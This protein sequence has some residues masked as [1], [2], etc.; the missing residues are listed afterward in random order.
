MPDGIDVSRWQGSID[1][2]TVAADRAFAYIKAGG[3][4]GGYYADPLWSQNRN[5]S[6]GLLPR[7][8]YY[9][10]APGD[11][12]AQAKHFAGIVGDFSTL[13]L[14]PALDVEMVGIS[15]DQV[16]AFMATLES[17]TPCRW[18][19]P[20]GTPQVAIIYSGLALAGIF[21]K[22]WT[23]WDLWLAGYYGGPDK[24]PRIPGPWSAWSIWQWIGEG[25]RCLGVNGDC[26]QNIATDEWWNRVRKTPDSGDWLDMA[27]IDDVR[28]VVREIVQQEM[29]NKDA[30]DKAYH[31]VLHAAVMGQ[32]A[33]R[34][35]DAPVLRDLVEQTFNQTKKDS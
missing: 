27:S 26:D 12:A 34:T 33:P 28:N 21:R 20:E 5:Q 7:G 15:S 8:A 3:A 9:F 23:R 31:D 14:P 22:S 29:A 25:G 11:G 32:L 16:E 2:R 6:N 13:E 30:R 24:R 18:T 35:T 19:G 4:D 1:W 17:L 10:L